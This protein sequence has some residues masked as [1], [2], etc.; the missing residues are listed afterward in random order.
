MRLEEWTSTSGLFKPPSLERGRIPLNGSSRAQRILLSAATLVVCF[1]LAEGAAR[2]TVAEPRQWLWPQVTFVE[3]PSLGFRLK[4]GQVAY[5]ADKPFLINA[6][7]FR[8]PERT[9]KK[10][11]GVNRVLVLGDSIAFGYGVAYEDSFPRRLEG[12]LNSSHPQAVYEVIDSGVPSFNTLQEVT[13]FHDEGID[14]EPDTV[15]LAVCW[16]DISPKSAVTVNDQ[17]QLVQPGARP[18]AYDR[19]T[20]SEQGY[21]VRNLLKR[22]D[23]LYFVV[24]RVRTVRERFGGDVPRAAAMRSA[25][26][27]G[28]ANPDVRAGWAEID[29]QVGVLAETSALKGIQVFIVALPMPALIEGGPYPHSQYPSEITRLCQ[30]YDLRC[31]DMHPAFARQ[32]TNHASLFVPYD[33]DHPNERGHRIIAES[34]YTALRE[35]D[36]Q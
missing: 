13:Y 7:G 34:L 19:W 3:S 8:G 29:R 36:A 10:P 24:D 32:F 35:A 27:T 30:K 25:V 15:I 31:L 6:Q 4:P 22:S 18:S 28:A 2:L 17:G 12:L 11:Q 9:R 26:L 23:F 20:E 33:G 21:W 1:I 14:F 16:N 5:T